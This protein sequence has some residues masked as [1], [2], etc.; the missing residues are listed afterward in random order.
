VPT[1]VEEMVEDLRARLG[2]PV[3]NAAGGTWRLLAMSLGGMVA[4]AWAQRYPEEI[5]A[6][7]LVNTS[8]RPFSPPTARLRPR[9]WAALGMVAARWPDRAHCEAEIFRLTCARGD[10]AQADIARWREIARSA[11]VSRE[12]AWRQ[13]LAA[14]RFRAASIA[15]AC[16]T[17]VV[18]S[19]G[20][21]LVN[22][23]CSLRLAQAWQ[24][25]HLRHPWAGHDL[26][27]DDPAWLCQAARGWL[28]RQAA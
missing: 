22:P 5:G 23:E 10:T 27:H 7:V 16:P 1:S 2:S 4:T 28:A 11:P 20:D 21:A 13:L 14:A 15:P 25:T 26:P 19:D 17:L 3:A 8:M 9:N 24:V 18:S 12:A 6:L